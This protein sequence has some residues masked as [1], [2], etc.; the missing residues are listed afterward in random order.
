MHGAEH[1]HDSSKD[2]CL[3]NLQNSRPFFYLYYKR[4][5]NSANVEN[6]DPEVGDMPLVTERQDDFEIGCALSNS[7]GFGGT[8]ASLAFKA[9]QTS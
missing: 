8:N 9:M 1:A 3:Q 6:V 7:F 4:V 2:K 5:S